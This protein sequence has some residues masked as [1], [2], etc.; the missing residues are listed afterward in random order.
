MGAIRGGQPGWGRVVKLD[1]DLCDERGNVCV[2]MQGISWQPADGVE[3]V[4]STKE[5]PMGLVGVKR[6]KPADI[7]L[8]APSTFASANPVRQPSPSRAAITLSPTTLP[9][10]GSVSPAESSVRLYDDGHGIFSIQIVAM[11]QQRK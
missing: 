8:P 11:G 1:V 2:Q 4:V 10:A 9:L 5:I 6:K 7:V 3:P